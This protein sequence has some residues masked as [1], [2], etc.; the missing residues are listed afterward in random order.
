MS[1]CRSSTITGAPAEKSIDW[2]K[3]PDE[4]LATDLDDT[5]LVGDA[6]AQEKHRR[7]CAA[8]EVEKRQKEEEERQQREAEAEQKQEAEKAKRATAAEAR[9]WQRADSE[10]QASGS[11]TNVSICIRLCAKAKERCEWT[12]SR[13]RMSP[14]AGEHKK[15]AKKVADGDDDDEIVILS[16]QKTSRQGGGKTLKEITN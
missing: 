16:S 9:K 12:A 3:V 7:L 5:D 2:T 6:K 10:A 1:M 14:Q 11:W 4:E 13:A 8:E 15:Q